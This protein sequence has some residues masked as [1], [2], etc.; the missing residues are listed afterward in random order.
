MAR[1]ECDYYENE[2]VYDW[3]NIT[4]AVNSNAG[5]T[6][7]HNMICCVKGQILSAGQYYIYPMINGTAGRTTFSGQSLQAYQITHYFYIRRGDVLKEY[8]KDNLDGVT[9]WAIQI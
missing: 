3:N 2:Q 7:P 5:Y 1:Q 6:A 4:T 8:Q 9:Y